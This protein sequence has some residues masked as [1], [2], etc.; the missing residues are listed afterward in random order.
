MKRFWYFLYTSTMSQNFLQ[1]FEWKACKFLGSVSL[2][3]KILETICHLRCIPVVF[4]PLQLTG[5]MSLMGRLSNESTV[6]CVTHQHSST[7]LLETIKVFDQ[8]HIES[9]EEVAM[10]SEQMTINRLH[11]MMANTT[12]INLRVFCF[13]LFFLHLHLSR[14]LTLCCRVLTL[15]SWCNWRSSNFCLSNSQTKIPCWRWFNRRRFS[16][17]SW[18]CQRI[19]QSGCVPVSGGLE[20]KVQ[21]VIQRQNHW[22]I[23]KHWVMRRRNWVELVID[24]VTNR[25][26]WLVLVEHCATERRKGLKC[27]VIQR[28]DGF[29]SSH[30]RGLIFLKHREHSSSPHYSARNKLEEYFTINSPSA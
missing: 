9:C 8:L 16:C 20:L 5:T 13:L 25:R 1:V 18:S 23:L 27:L 17:L 19:F 10:D 6:A 22:K 11:E 26:K 2:N 4:Q 15:C 7:A 21:W 28:R 24:C 12:I 29:V 3:E 14:F 30:F